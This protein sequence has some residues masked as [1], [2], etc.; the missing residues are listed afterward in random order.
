PLQAR[1]G[2]PLVVVLVGRRGQARCRRGVGRRR[3]RGRGGRPARAA[4]RRGRGVCPAVPQRRQAPARLAPPP[5]LRL[6]APLWLPLRPLEALVP[7]PPPQRILVLGR[8]RRLGGFD[9]CAQGR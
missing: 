1:H 5:L 9:S 8:Q 7:P 2:R 6:P 4:R 3:W